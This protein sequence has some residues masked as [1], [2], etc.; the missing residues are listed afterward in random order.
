MEFLI[1]TVNGEVVHD[2]SFT[3]LESIRYQ[4]WL[5]NEIQYLLSDRINTS[6]KEKELV[7]VGTVEFVLEF[8]GEHY[9]LT[10]K[11]V[12]VPESLFHYAWRDI[13]NGT[14]DDINLGYFFKSN[15]KIK[16]PSGYFD[17]HSVAD[18][19]PGNY[20]ISKIIQIHS[21]WRAFIFHKELVGL[22]NY[23]GDF[24]IFPHIPT[25]K[26]MIKDFDG[27]PVAYTLDVG[28][29]EEKDRTFVIEV[30]DFFSC[31]LYGFRD[32]SKYPYMLSQ[33]FFEFI[34]RAR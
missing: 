15:D 4:K 32:H 14:H 30:H 24:T 33:W 6:S 19:P 25:I 1:Q 31:G 5:G 17:E 23:S 8:M 16:G 7:P 22:Q 28:V 10:P 11:P 27:Q 9:G 18:I 20:Q 21:E 13:F 29:D 12:N 26:K 34:R 3:L 2:F